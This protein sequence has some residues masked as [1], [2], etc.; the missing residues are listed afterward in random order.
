MLRSPHM[1][2]IS[3]LGQKLWTLGDVT[4]ARTGRTEF[5]FAVTFTEKY[6]FSICVFNSISG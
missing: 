4:D 2:K 3:I 6:V 5:F 1:Q